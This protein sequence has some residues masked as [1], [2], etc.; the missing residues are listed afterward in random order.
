LGEIKE[1]LVLQ[2]GEQFSCQEVKEQLLK[3][4]A[5]LDQAIRDLQALRAQLEPLLA[6]CK[7]SSV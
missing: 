3:K 1:L 6:Q 4:M 2:E 7:L 5:Q